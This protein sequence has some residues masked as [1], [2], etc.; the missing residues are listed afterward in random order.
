MRVFIQPLSLK[1]TWPFDDLPSLGSERKYP[2]LEI[3]PG[4]A[5]N[6]CEI[7]SQRLRLRAKLQ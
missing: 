6:S 5:S 2:I 3:L 1:I 7:Q 4:F